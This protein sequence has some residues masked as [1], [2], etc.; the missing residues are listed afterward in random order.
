MATIGTHSGSFQADEAL[1]VW[2]LKRLPLYKDS[3][4]IRS[5]DTEVLKPLTIVIDVAGRYEHDILRYDHHQRGFFETFDGQNKDFKDGGRPDVTGPE[6]AT[7]KFKTKLSAAGLV[8]KHYGREVIS[9]LHPAMA[10]DP[11]ALEWVFDKMYKDFMEGLDA[12]DNGIGT[13]HIL[14]CCCTH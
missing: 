3:P 10:K 7:G 2:M 8:Y 13:L 14:A 4:V 12:D 6:T 11:D 1:G 9:A 5:R